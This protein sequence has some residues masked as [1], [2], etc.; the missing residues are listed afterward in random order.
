METSPKVRLDILIEQLAV[1]RLEELLNAQSGVNGYTVLPVQGGSGLHGIWTRE[2]Q[3][4]Q[5]ESMVNVWCILD[6]KHKE[7]VLDAVFE[8]VDRRAGIVVVSEVEVVRGD[9]F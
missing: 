9:R 4:G 7:A 1:P 5:S 3:V 8:F 6:R 2:G